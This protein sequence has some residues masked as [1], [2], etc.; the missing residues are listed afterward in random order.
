MLTEPEVQEALDFLELPTEDVIGRFLD[1][2]RSIALPVPRCDPCVFVPGTRKSR[3]LLV[4]HSD[5][6]WDHDPA[7]TV[8]LIGDVVTSGT[9]QVGIGA[10]DRA[11]CFILW[12]LRNSGHSL[13]LCSDEEAG[14][15]GARHIAKT[16]ALQD[17]LFALEFDRC[18]PA[19]IVNYGEATTPFID[20]LES[21]YSGFSESTGSFSDICEICPTAGIQGVNLSVGYY[22]EHTAEELLHLG[23]LSHT[24]G[25]TRNLLSEAT[26]PGFKLPEGYTRSKSLRWNSPATRE[27]F[28]R[29]AFQAGVTTEAP[30]DPNDLRSLAERYDLDVNDLCR[31]GD[32]YCPTCDEIIENTETVVFDNDGPDPIRCC[33]TCYGTVHRLEAYN[34]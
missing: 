5:T 8:E 24:L 7:R 22:S 21:Y 10:D 15:L 2:K 9:P 17:H 33:E 19:D 32:F 29:T 12:A 6:V 27:S 14:C 16:P 30:F 3:V 31:F 20:Y 4:A 1:L 23:M 25:C 28:W 18:G 11:G 34:L 13:L 26:I